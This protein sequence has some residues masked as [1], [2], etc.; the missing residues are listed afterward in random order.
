MAPVIEKGGLK[1]LSPG[2]LGRR[3]S[4]LSRTRRRPWSLGQLAW[5]VS[6]LSGKAERL[7]AYAATDKGSSVSPKRC[8]ELSCLVMPTMIAM[9]AIYGARQEAI[10]CWSARMRL[11][12]EA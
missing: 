5:T 7:P 6:G 9:G 4:G 10:G 11:E 1:I 3:A 12:K 8:A 2:D